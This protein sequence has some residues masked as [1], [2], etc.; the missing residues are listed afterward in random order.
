MNVSET[1]TSKT[2]IPPLIEA[3]SAIIEAG[4]PADDFNLIV[5]FKPVN[6][7]NALIS[8]VEA[9]KRLNMTTKI[10]SAHLE[11]QVLICAQCR[12]LRSDGRLQAVHH[13][14][15][16]SQAIVLNSNWLLAN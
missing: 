12:Y 16:F 14:P 2:N 5:P 1:L 6:L 4:V 3:V 11:M 15:A 9:R 10:E 7:K 13:A 8:V